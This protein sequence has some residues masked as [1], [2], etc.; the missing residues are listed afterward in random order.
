[1]PYKEAFPIGSR[2][3]IADLRELTEFRRSWKYHHPLEEGQL[4][5]A[6]IPATVADVGFFHGGDVLYELSGVPGQWHECCLSPHS[7]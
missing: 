6:G 5:F 2:V 7:A 1:M 3:R 4:A